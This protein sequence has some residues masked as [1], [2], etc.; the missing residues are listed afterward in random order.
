MPDEGAV[1]RVLQPARAER[2]V[3]RVDIRVPP[4]ALVRDL[5]SSLDVRYALIAEVIPTLDLL[6]YYLHEPASFLLGEALFQAREYAPA[7]TAYERHVERFPQATTVPAQRRV[8]DEGDPQAVAGLDQLQALGYD[9]TRVD[10][11]S[12]YDEFA[13]YS[14]SVLANG[15]ALVPQYTDSTKNRNA[16]RAYESLGYTAYGVD[17]RLII[18]YSGATHCV[19]MQIPAGN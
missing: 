19:S 12:S 14:N 8:G 9:V 2:R 11:D 15:I 10:V 13:T 16:L 5:A 17:S 18:R 1:R 3:A 4:T 7:A 6:D